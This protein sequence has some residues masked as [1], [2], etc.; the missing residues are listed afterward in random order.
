MGNS[1]LRLTDE[2]SHCRIFCMNVLYNFCI[3][4]CE[5]PYPSKK[6]IFICIQLLYRIALFFNYFRKKWVVSFYNYIYKFMFCKKSNFVYY[7]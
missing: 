7:A 3:N 4:R 5:L 1:V 2:N 6:S